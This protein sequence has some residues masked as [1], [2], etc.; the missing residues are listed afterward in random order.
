MYEMLSTEGHSEQ[1]TG[2]AGAS[3]HSHSKTLN[4]AFS[5]P[6]T[7]NHGSVTKRNACTIPVRFIIQMHH[8][9]TACGAHR[10]QCVE[11]GVQEACVATCV[12]QH[13]V[14]TH[15]LCHINAMQATTHLC[16][17]TSRLRCAI[18]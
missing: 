7:Q 11:C 15:D 3:R 10:L 17:L 1:I 2:P 18:P 6:A 13:V 5:P 16:R 12:R 4:L 8:F 9:R 14:L